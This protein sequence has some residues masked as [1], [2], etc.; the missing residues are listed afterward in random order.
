MNA[1]QARKERRRYGCK[2][3]YYCFWC[4]TLLTE[5]EEPCL[6]EHEH[7]MERRPFLSLTLTQLYTRGTAR[8]VRVAFSLYKP[9][10]L[11]QLAEVP[12]DEPI[13]NPNVPSMEHWVA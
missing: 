5:W 13:N 6:C 12:L 7:R 9:T 10:P 3:P 4:H 11:E 8:R 1:G 2:P